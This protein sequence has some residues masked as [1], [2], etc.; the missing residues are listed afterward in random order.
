MSWLERVPIR[1]RV[2]AAFAGVMLVVL[3]ATGLFLYL[4]LGSELDATI[5]QGLRSRAVDVTALVEQA[6][7]GLSEG[8]SPLTERGENL[9]E[10]IGSDGAVLDS[11]PALRGRPLLDSTELARA[12]RGTV[13][14]DKSVAG[15]GDEV[16]LLAT[17]VQAQGR[18][19]V[20][21]VGASLE[22]RR[23][24]LRN[25]AGL[26]LLGGPV[27][28]LLAS[29]AGYGVAAA[30]LRP[31]ERMR[32][33]AAEISMVE[34]GRRLP[35]PPAD[36]EISR[37]GTTLNAMLDRLQEAFA[38]ERRFVSD[39]SHEL[40]T[41]LAILKAELE[42]ALRDARTEA[43]F[44]A[45]TASA[46]EET[47]RL[48]QLAE[49]LLVIAR[50]DQGRLPLRAEAVEVGALLE[51]VQQRFAGR[52]A[53][54]QATLT[55]DARD[56]VALTADPL[57]LEQALG[58]LVENAIGHGGHRIELVATPRDDAVEIHVLDDGPGFPERFLPSA[59]ERFSR[60]DAARGRGGAGL[61]LAIVA[62]VA[63]AHGG[64]ARAA[65]RPEGGADVWLRL[66][67]DEPGS[68][69]RPAR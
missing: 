28:L 63:E 52:L 53:E 11:T 13:I 37:L 31:V 6:D 9:A 8:R 48:V 56:G 44:R 61:G 59:F 22:D 23:D 62:A 65:N 42:L 69:V 15:L 64:S 55:V 60:A 67:R 43:D 24:A 68:P 27:S 54:R 58:N 57:R 21:V 66:P 34:P 2:T 20:V 1:V 4:R 41:P 36:D 7:S 38:H 30:A 10:I 33:R 40:R 47:D 29:L 46:A 16:R 39:A 50:S 18:E 12:E 14:I 25:L 5:R 19:V 51:G 35:V 32:R 3:A 45:A 17:P 26:L 49:D